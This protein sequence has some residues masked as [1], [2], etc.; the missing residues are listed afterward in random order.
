MSVNNERDPELSLYYLGGIYLNI[1]EQK[2]VISIENL[3]SETQ[4]KLNKKIHIDFLYYALDWLFLLS[5][6]KLEE[7]KVYYENKKIN[8]TQNGAF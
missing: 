4:V 3:F 1:L 2:K 7:G 8:S 6:I 5:L